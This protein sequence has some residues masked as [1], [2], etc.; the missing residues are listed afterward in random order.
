MLSS[1]SLYE[2][3]AQTNER[4]KADSVGGHWGESTFRGLREADWRS[5]LMRLKHARALLNKDSVSS[6][7][8][9]KKA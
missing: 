9:C 8:C 2:A 3:A 6:A 7:S 4:G 5:L 1:H